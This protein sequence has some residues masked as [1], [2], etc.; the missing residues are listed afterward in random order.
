M[1][2]SLATFCARRRDSGVIIGP[3]R[4][5]LV[6][7]A[8]AARATHGSAMALA[9]ER[10][11]MWSQTKNPSQPRSSAAAASSASTRGSASS[12]NGGTSIACFTRAF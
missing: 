8:T 4:S 7:Q 5:R 2:V 6:A 12:P 11:T 9:G 10:C 1:T 3:I